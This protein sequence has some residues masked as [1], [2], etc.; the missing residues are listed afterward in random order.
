[1]VVLWEY[2]WFVFQIIVAVLIAVLLPLFL[3]PHID[4]ILAA[5]PSWFHKDYDRVLEESQRDVISQ[6]SA[7][8]VSYRYANKFSA[9]FMIALTGVWI[10]LFF[11][12]FLP[13]SL[14]DAL[15]VN[16]GFQFTLHPDHTPENQSDAG[17]VYEIKD[18]KLSFLFA[19]FSGISLAWICLILAGQVWPRLRDYIVLMMPFHKRG[20]FPI[21][22]KMTHLVR[23]KRLQLNENT[24]QLTLIKAMFNSRNGTAAWFFI[25]SSIL[26]LAFTFFD[27]YTFTHVSTDKIES[28]A[29]FSNKIYTY[30]FS[31]IEAVN[32]NCHI[33]SQNNKLTARLD[34]RVRLNDGRDVSI[35]IQ[36]ASSNQ[37]LY[38]AHLIHKALN[39]HS[40]GLD[41]L[42]VTYS[43][44]LIQKSKANSR[45]CIE[46]LVKQ[47]GWRKS[48]MIDE[49]LQ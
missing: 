43:T 1:M 11:I 17:V 12:L 49:L 45:A 7:D 41:L 13:M 25:I 4:R 33:F 47:Y 14:L 35:R 31:D 39:R 44:S 5:I 10:A 38:A 46:L 40:D 19:F 29:Y 42:A 34:Y 32:R 24:S 21:K 18:P 48:S 30:S 20:N 36:R 37:Q 28:R 6:K 27:N 16:N 26:T 2:I 8:L 23:L 22:S 3:R 15:E 9:G